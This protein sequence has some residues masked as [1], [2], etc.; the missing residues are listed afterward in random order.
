MCALLLMEQAVRLLVIMSLSPRKRQLYNLR[1]KHG[2]GLI[3]IDTCGREACGM[4]IRARCATLRRRQRA[5]TQTFTS[6]YKM[7]NREQWQIVNEVAL[8]VL[9]A[10]ILTLTLCGGGMR[11]T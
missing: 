4:L 8:C 5:E 3:F 1:S 11:E 2:R 9:N 7:R 10:T 6:A